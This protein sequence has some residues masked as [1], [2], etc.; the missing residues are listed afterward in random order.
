MATS[1]SSITP[2]IWCNDQAE[3]AAE[4]YARTFPAG[5]VFAAAR[6]RPCRR[7]EHEEARYR[8]ARARATRGVERSL[9]HTRLRAA[10]SSPGT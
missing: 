7:L 6:A 1:G 3:E 10:A 2:C 4:F 9:D 8:G 5:R